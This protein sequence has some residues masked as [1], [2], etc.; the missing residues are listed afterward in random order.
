MKRKSLFLGLILGFFTL[1]VL[2]VGKENP[3]KSQAGIMPDNVSKIIEQKCFGCHNT[4]SKNDKAKE[5]LDF[6]T[7]DG[8]S[9]MK[10]V[11]S[12]NKI[13]EVL[14]KQEMP[15]KKFLERFPDKDV[16]DE[17]RTALLEWAKNEAAALIKGN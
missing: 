5:D 2:A 13:A 6:K 15:P 9:T 8:L 12:Y 4:D 1:S 11:S 14:E 3:T 7:L 10:K 16:T 17:E